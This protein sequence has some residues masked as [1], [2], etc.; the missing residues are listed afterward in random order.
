MKILVL[1]GRGF[2]G[3]SV[4]SA[5][6]NQGQEVIIGSRF[7]NESD[8]KVRAVRMEKML[9]PEQW[10]D[11]LGEADMQEITVIVNCVGIL[12][13][14][15]GERYDDV[16]NLAP[17]ALAQVCQLKG[18]RLVHVSALG[19]SATAGSGFIRS[20]YAGE[21][22]LLNSGAEVVIVQPSLLDGTGNTHGFGA[23][24]LRRVAKW[25]IHFVMN[26]PTGLVAPLKVADLGEAIANICKLS[27][28]D[29]P[30]TVELGAREGITIEQYLM[31]LRAEYFA[32][33]ALVIK[34]PV[35]I[36]RLVSHIFDA[37]HFS[38]L[39]FGHVELMQGRNVPVNNM[40]KVLLGR[41]PEAVGLS[42]DFPRGVQWETK[43][44]Q[45][46]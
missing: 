24:W 17:A 6:Q 15:W 42:K 14:R 35:W 20:K 44:R 45:P 9:L 36:V 34:V 23:R 43:S 1:G 30:T 26:T 40:L 33:K 18:I 29:L 39:S 21:L 2:I 25:P 4:V 37:I 28:Q 5:L 31:N 19:L 38:P 22:A 32:S 3:G 16:H 7:A 13:E 8:R 12:R 46:I 10:V 11:L 27:T 41:E